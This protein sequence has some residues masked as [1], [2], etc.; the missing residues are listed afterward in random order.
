MQLIQETKLPECPKPLQITG[1]RQNV[2]AAHRFIE[3]RYGME[4]S[5]EMNIP[6]KSYQR[7]RDF[8]PQPA[9]S[10]ARLQIPRAYVKWVI[11][12]NG[13]NIKRLCMESGGARIQFDKNGMSL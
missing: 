10:E 13:N 3:V 5:M 4:D 8:Q 2:E 9:T 11:G 12:V 6:G 1:S 7:D